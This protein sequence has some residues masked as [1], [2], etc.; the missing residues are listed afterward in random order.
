MISSIVFLGFFDA[1][2]EADEAAT[3]MM[4]VPLRVL[5]CLRNY[6]LSA[7]KQVM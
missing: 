4:S 6:T 3:M 1:F 7:S 5:I 2:I